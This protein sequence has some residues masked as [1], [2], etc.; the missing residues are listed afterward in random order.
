MRATATS[1]VLA[2][3]CMVLA[4]CRLG[5]GRHPH[6]GGGGRF[7]RRMNRSS[8]KRLLA[9]GCVWAL[10]LSIGAATEGAVFEVT[11]A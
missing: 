9:L 10:P 3:A 8:L 7:G 11:S 5:T 1:R 4:P 2:A 6:G